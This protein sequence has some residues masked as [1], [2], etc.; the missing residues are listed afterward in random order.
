MRKDEELL[1]LTEAS[2]VSLIIMLISDIMN[3]CRSGPSGWE[4]VILLT[5]PSW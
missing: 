4:M 5:G 1:P 2:D 3:S